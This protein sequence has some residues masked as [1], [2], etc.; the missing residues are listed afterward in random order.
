[1]SDASQGPFAIPRIKKEERSSLV[2]I[3]LPAL[4]IG[5]SSATEKLDPSAVK[6]AILYAIRLAYTHFQTE[7]SS[8]LEQLVGEAIA[9]AIGNG[10]VQ[11][12][13]ELYITAKIRFTN[14]SSDSI[15]PN[16]KKS[17]QRL[18]LES[19]RIFLI[20]WPENGD[21][22][23]ADA[24]T[25]AW[26]AMEECQSLGLAK[27]IG[28][29]NFSTEMLE[30]LLGFATSAPVANQ[31]GMERMWRDKKLREYCS[32]N[33]IVILVSAAVD[34]EDKDFDYDQFMESE[35]LKIEKD[36]VLKTPAQVY[37]KWAYEQGAAVLLQSF[38]QQLMKEMLDIFR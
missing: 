19:V 33:D 13:D 35:G 14:G 15:V 36:G 7:S 18:N 27:E 17:L 12:T 16:L 20:E 5:T 30:S 38:N 9:E 32:D 6:A 28:V 4:G 23:S 34:G 11:S 37:F 10:T 2:L 31:I 26:R 29:S 3:D 24:F 21:T 25:S 8:Y 22:F 1:M